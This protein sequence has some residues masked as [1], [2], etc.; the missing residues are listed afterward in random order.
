M[1]QEDKQ[2]DAPKPILFKLDEDLKASILQSLKSKF[3]E[4]RFVSQQRV[5]ESNEVVDFAKDR[6]RPCWTSMSKACS[7][8]HSEAADYA[9]NRAAL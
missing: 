5:M 2:E 8:H 1:A 3:S 7:G 9:Q 4:T 6:W